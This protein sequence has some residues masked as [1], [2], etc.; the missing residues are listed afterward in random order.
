MSEVEVSQ[1]SD[2]DLLDFLRHRGF[3][4]TGTRE[5]MILTTRN[6]LY[7]LREKHGLREMMCEESGICT[8][9]VCDFL[10]VM[11]YAFTDRPTFTVE[12]IMRSKA[13]DRSDVLR[14]FGLPADLNRVPHSHNRILRIMWF[15]GYIDP[16]VVAANGNVAP[17]MGKKSELSPQLRG[18]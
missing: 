6:T 18:F 11:I 3:T 17:Y 9:A 1:L 7:Q 10:S 13:G 12:G 16:S 15:G 4:G 5:E 8:Q 2:G 14:L